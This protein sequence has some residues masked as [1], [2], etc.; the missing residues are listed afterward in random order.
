ME[1]STY[2]R[3]DHLLATDHHPDGWYDD[4]LD[5]AE[6][7]VA[8]L[9]PEEWDLLEFGLE[10]RPAHWQRQLADALPTDD[11]H[12]RRLL[13]RLLRSDHDTVA[14]VALASLRAGGWSPTVQDTAFLESVRRRLPAAYRPMVEDILLR[15]PAEDEHR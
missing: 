13:S 14:G 12:G 11:E 3:L 4:L 6:T 7:L 1:M 10:S 8:S 9:T 15:V 5:H 2:G